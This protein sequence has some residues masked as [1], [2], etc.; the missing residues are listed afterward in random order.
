M[1]FFDSKY[2]SSDQDQFTF[3]VPLT[4]SGSLIEYKS[5]DYWSQYVNLQNVSSL[6]KIAVILAG[7]N[8]SAINLNGSEWEMMLELVCD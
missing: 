7:P 2:I 4:S 8:N 5:K 3:Y 6:T 1:P